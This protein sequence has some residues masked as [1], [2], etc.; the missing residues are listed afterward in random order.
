MKK[1][2]TIILGS[3][4]SLIAQCDEGVVKKNT[5]SIHTV[6]RGSMP[7]FSSASGTVTSLH[8]RRAVL[9]FSSNGERCES[10]RA[11]RLVIRDNPRAFIAKVL[12]RTDAGD[13]EVEFLDAL[14]DSTVAGQTVEGLIVTGE[15]DDTVFFGR[16]AGSLPNT[17]VTIFVLQD[18]SRARRATVRYGVRSGPL[19]QVLEGLEAGDRVIVTDMS[20]WAGVA[21]VRLE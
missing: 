19:I 16:P 4:S 10:G 20:K 12:G 18:S 11:A 9:H 2:L 14:P 8:P 6:E 21:T 1:P 13:C 7:T 3:L 5:L 17:T 15:I